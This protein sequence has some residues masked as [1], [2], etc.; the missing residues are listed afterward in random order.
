M[1]EKQAIKLS[2]NGEDHAVLIDSRRTLLEVL[3]E[4]LSLTG[5]KCGCNNG[6]C[7]SCTI[8][9]DNLP[10]R[11][12]LTLAVAA[13]DREIITIEGLETNGELHPVQKAIVEKQGLQCGFCTPGMVIAIKA[14][15]DRNPSPSID[16]IRDEL[17]GNLCRCTGYVKIVDAVLSLTQGE[18]A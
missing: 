15:L 2:I 18:M 12:C 9:I 3:R 14:L 11:A 13:T 17:S 5:T 16:E 1:T 4:Q 7:G 6:V 8:L 10:M